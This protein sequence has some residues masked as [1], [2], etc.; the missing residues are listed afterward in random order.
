[1]APTQKTA[2]KQ[3]VRL[4]V[5]AVVT[6]FRRAKRTQDNGTVLL[7]LENVE[8]KAATQTYAGKRVCYIY[9]AN[10]AAA[11]QKFRTIWGKIGNPHGSN[12][13]VKAKFSTNLPGTALGAPARVMLYPSK[14]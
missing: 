7:K 5:K 1:M 3:S 13:L 11:G 4:Y 9:R 6:S 12:G 8:D 2:K 10:K 14:I